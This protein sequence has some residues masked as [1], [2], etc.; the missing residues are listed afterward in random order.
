MKSFLSFALS[1]LLLASIF[2]GCTGENSETAAANDHS[3]QVGFGR[4]DI[5]PQD[6]VPMGGY[7][8]SLERIST[9]VSDPLYATC[10]AFTDETGNTVLLFHT[11]LGSAGTDDFMWA[12]ADISK[13]TGV[14]VNRVIISCTHAHSNPDMRHIQLPSI[15]KYNASFRE[16]VVEAAEAAMADRKPAKLYAAE[17]RPV[18]YNFVRHYITEDGEIIGDNFGERN[19]R[20]L[21]AH[22]SEADNQLQLIKITR[23]GGE[24]IVLVNWQGHPH[25]AGGAKK[26]N[27]TADLVGAMRSYM[28]EKIGCKFAYFTGGSGNVNNHSRIEGEATADDY[29]SHGEGLGQI[30]IDALN[31]CKPLVEGNVQLTK[32]TLNL[33]LKDATD[34]FPTMDI[35]TFSIGDIGFAIAPYEMFDINGMEIKSGSK[36]ETTFIVTCAN[37]SH[38]YI[39]SYSAYHYEEIFEG[40]YFL[41]EEPYGVQKTK[42]VEGTGELLAQEYVKMLNALYETRK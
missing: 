30:A 16:W 31:N 12:R 2:A 4:V 18:G 22:T 11:D 38:S 35:W 40:K 9:E 39:P 36:F 10:I 32:Q 5:S 6:P 41:T 29:I 25:R 1:L 19:G 27:I 14:P 21:V 28:E 15:V 7:S 20:N 23:E 13:A 17:A 8:N 24:D 37:A 42:Y 26:T 34:G 3:L 33:E